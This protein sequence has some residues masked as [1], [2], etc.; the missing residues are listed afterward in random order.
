MAPCLHMDAG[1][2]RCRREAEEGVPF[3]SRHAPESG[4]PPLVSP[5][6]RRVV[7]RLA[8]LILLALFLIPLLVQGYRVLRALLN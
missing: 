1:G 5:G 6:T 4:A 8:A 7:F 3:C 2:R